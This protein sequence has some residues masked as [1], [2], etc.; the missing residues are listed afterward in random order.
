MSRV[1]TRDNFYSQVKC[2]QQQLASVQRALLGRP[3]KDVNTTGLTSAQIDAATFGGSEG[4]AY[5]GVQIT[6]KTNSLL[7]VRV[8]GKWGKTLLT[9]IP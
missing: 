7:L 1:Q 2:D 9:I 5:D 8:S 3:L 4:Q 6:D